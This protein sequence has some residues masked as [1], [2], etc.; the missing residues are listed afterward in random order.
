[1]RLGLLWRSPLGQARVKLEWQLARLGVPYIDASIISGTTA[2]WTDTV[3]AG[4]VIA[5]A[6]TALSPGTRYHWRLRLIYDPVSWLGQ[7]ASRWV[8]VP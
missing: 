8:H 7:P 1:M 5:P 4:A 2:D 6:I 3:I